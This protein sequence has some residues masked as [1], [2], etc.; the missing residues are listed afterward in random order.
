MQSNRPIQGCGLDGDIAE[1]VWTLAKYDLASNDT[2]RHYSTPSD[3]TYRDLKK[4][5]Q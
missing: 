4:L 2:D 5:S 1:K 3:S